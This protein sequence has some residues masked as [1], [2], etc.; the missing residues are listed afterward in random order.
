MHFECCTD[1]ITCCDLRRSTESSSTKY[2]VIDLRSSATFF[3]AAAGLS[4]SRSQLKSRC[5]LASAHGGS[6]LRL[7]LSPMKTLLLCNHWKPLCLLT[8]RPRHCGAH[9]PQ[10]PI[11]LC[12]SKVRPLTVCGQ[13]RAIICRCYN[14]CVMHAINQSHMV[15]MQLLAIRQ[16][17]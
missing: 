16:C 17:H 15:A 4:G 3:D 1:W 10:T 12:F 5:A 9:L 13:A 11:R 14:S 8:T 2:S 6:R 7:A